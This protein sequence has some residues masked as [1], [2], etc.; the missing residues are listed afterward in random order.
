[1]RGLV[2][3]NGTGQIVLD[4]VAGLAT[5]L[6]GE[7][8]ADAGRALALRTLGGDPDHA[9]G[10]RQLLIL[11]HEVQQHEHLVAESVIAAGRDEQ[12][13]VLYERHIGQVERALVLDRQ[14]Q[15]ARLVDAGSRIWVLGHVPERSS[16]LQAVKAINQDAAAVRVPRRASCH[17]SCSSATARL[18]AVSRK[19]RS[20]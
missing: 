13:T 3:G 9:A 5:V 20:S 6:F 17:S 16:A 7:L 8:H 2:A 4:L 14:G 10:D 1:M 12:P 19:P 18:I 11:T 15:K